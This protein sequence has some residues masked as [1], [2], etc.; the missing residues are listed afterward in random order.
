MLDRLTPVRSQAPAPAEPATAPPEPH[1][2]R[3]TSAAPPGSAAP[4]PPATK[5]RRAVDRDA[6]YAEVD[7]LAA[8]YRATPDPDLA[9]ALIDKRFEAAEAYDGAPARADWPP[10]YTDPFPDKEPGTLPEVPAAE[11]TTEVVA[12]AIAHHGCCVVRGLFSPER[13]QRTIDAVHEVERR[14]AVPEDELVPDA[15]YRPF[16]GIDP[17]HQ[18]LR[19]MVHQQGGTWLADSPIA[20]AQ[21]LD[22]L[23]EVG[24]IDVVADHFGERPYFSLQKSTLRRSP[25]VHNFSGWHQDGSF[26]GPEVR[27]LNVWVALTDC[28]GDRPTPGL[29]VVPRRVDVL[30]DTDGGLGSASISD[31]QVHATAGDTPTITP[32]FDAGDALVFDQHFV[33]RTHLFPEMTDDRYALECWLFAPSFAAVEYVPLVV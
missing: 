9:V 5:E 22:D 17:M 6:L 33:H 10:A 16:T 29:E 12:G 4:T 1:A 27:T 19:R 13:V 32:P 3:V 8:R 11:M 30:L 15:W 21:V 31:A 23:R 14:R 7:T 2:A 24:V 26:L 28:G 20:S 18:A 25:P